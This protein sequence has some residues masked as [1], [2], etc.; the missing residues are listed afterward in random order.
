MLVFTEDA[1]EAVASM[2]VE[3]GELVGVGDRFGQWAERRGVC[4][5]AVGPV[6]VVEGLVFAQRVEEMGLVP[7]EGAVEELGSA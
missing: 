5:G 6:L 2:D 7:D 1:A 4:E 3:M